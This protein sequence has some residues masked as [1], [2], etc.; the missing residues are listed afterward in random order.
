LGTIGG[1]KGCEALIPLLKSASAEDRD[2]AV[3]AIGGARCSGAL[4][5]LIKALADEHHMVRADAA[6]ALGDLGDKR[7]VEPLLTL[8]NSAPGDS[9]RMAVV[10]ALGALH[11]RRAIG[12]LETL[13]KTEKNENIRPQIEQSLERLRA[14]PPDKQ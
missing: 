1:D 2:S 10:V 12:P 4:E 6:M 8:L 3:A 5:P 13:L 14:A 11:D 7:A 9:V